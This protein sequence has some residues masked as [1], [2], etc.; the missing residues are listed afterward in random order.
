MK[1]DENEYVLAEES[2]EYEDEMGKVI[3]N[4]RKM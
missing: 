4:S 2:A 1:E 3:F